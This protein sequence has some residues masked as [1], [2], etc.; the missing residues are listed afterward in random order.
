MD[1]GMGDVFENLGITYKLS[2]PLKVPFEP[3]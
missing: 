2:K 1:W 3:F